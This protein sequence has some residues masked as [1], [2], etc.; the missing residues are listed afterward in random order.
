MA[1]P[2]EKATPWLGVLGI[3]VSVVVSMVTAAIAVGVVYQ[4]VLFQGGEIKDIKT[5]QAAQATTSSDLK[6][7]LATILTTTNYLKDRAQE[8]RAAKQNRGGK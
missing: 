4:T 8:D 6:V 5:E 7:T 2:R 3:V 1:E